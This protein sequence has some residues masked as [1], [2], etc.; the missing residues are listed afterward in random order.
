MSAAPVDELATR[1]RSGDRRAAAQLRSQVAR[2]ARGLARTL[3]GSRRQA[4]TVV[5]S[6]M[7]EAL[8]DTERP[9]ASAVVL[10]ISRH[11]AAGATQE[12]GPEQR[13]RQ[14]VGVLCDVQGRSHDEAAALLGLPVGRVV[15]LHGQVREELGL[16]RASD[17]HGW[18]LVSRL[19]ELTA[20]E[21]AAGRRHLQACR[22]CADALQARAAARVRLKAALPVGGTAAAGALAVAAFS[23]LTSTGSGATVAAVG[24]VG[25]VTA[26]VVSVPVVGHERPDRPAIV[27]QAAP[28]ETAAA[29]SART[30][31]PAAPRRSAPSPTDLPTRSA[32]VPV[33]A[34]APS[35][36]ATPAPTRAPSPSP[37]PG[38][39]AGPSPSPT[40]AVPIPLLPLPRPSTS[41][42]L[43]SPSP[44][45]VP[46]LLGIP[47]PLLSPLLPPSASAGPT[48]SPLPSA[49]SSQVGTDKT[50]DKYRPGRSG[51]SAVQEDEDR[52]KD[53]ER[54]RDRRGND[55]DRTPS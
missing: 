44:L 7:S 43:P 48:P 23:A 1:A 15:A 9:Y 53:G 19:E 5:R 55:E 40:T 36:T 32:A 50:P 30:A 46:E 3:L 54:G 10:A 41:P 24:I 49:S 34:P 38:A 28:R 27:Q 51:R 21:Q 11:A 4:R 20:P 26:G 2:D 33:A 37:S 8:S 25:T 42:L 13:L 12:T 29:R 47:L 14:A 31:A 22:R 18:H 45:P 17:C 16:A 35:P 6:A 39:T 52:G